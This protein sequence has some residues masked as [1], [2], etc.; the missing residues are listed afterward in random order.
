M[1]VIKIHT[2]EY[3][4]FIDEEGTERFKPDNL[5]NKLRI[6]LDLSITR[7]IKLYDLGAINLYDLLK[8]FTAI[9][10]TVSGVQELSFFEDLEFKRI[11]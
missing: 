3:D 7:V 2:T 5:I 9:G 1:G 10:Y 8:Y 4:T 11:V 6:D